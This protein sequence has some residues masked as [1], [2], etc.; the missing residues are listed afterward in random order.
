MWLRTVHVWL[1]QRPSDRMHR[2]WRSCLLRPSAFLTWEITPPSVLNQSSCPWH[3]LAVDFL[4]HARHIKIFWL[5]NAYQ[6]YLPTSQRVYIVTRA[7]SNSERGIAKV[8]CVSTTSA[9]SHYNVQENCALLPSK[10]H[11][12]QFS[13][14][15]DVGP[16]GIWGQIWWRICHQIWW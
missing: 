8:I 6:V 7:W 15:Q 5:L 12:D 4:A 10:V 3:T 16:L 11:P 14:A 2:S 13:N 1:M 9:R